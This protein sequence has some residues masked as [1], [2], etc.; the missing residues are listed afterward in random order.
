MQPRLVETE[1]KLPTQK[2]LKLSL[3]WDNHFFKTFIFGSLKI[4]YDYTYECG[5]H[6]TKKPFVIFLSALVTDYL[7][8]LILFLYSIIRDHLAI[9]YIF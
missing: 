7:N 5:L 8:D 9:Q 1:Q 2:G 3:K 4:K 6:M